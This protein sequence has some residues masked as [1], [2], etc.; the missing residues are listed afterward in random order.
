[1]KLPRDLPKGL[2]TQTID[3]VK[4]F[5]Q[6]S[7]EMSNSKSP[8]FQFENFSDINDVLASRPE[9]FRVYTPKRIEFLEQCDFIPCPLRN[10][11]LAFC[12][13]I[14]KSPEVLLLPT[15]SI[16]TMIRS[17]SN[18]KD[19]HANDDVLSSL[20]STLG[21]RLFVLNKDDGLSLEEFGDHEGKTCSLLLRQGRSF[22]LASFNGDTQGTLDVVVAH[23]KNV[24]ANVK[25][26]PYGG[27]WRSLRNSRHC[28]GLEF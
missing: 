9:S 8:A 19:E 3:V 20:S 11:T 12:A 28:K 27:I 15:K 14:I 6:G 13:L 5:E 23:A 4:G 25:E 1:M 2:V 7:A 18:A 26:N 22:S 24:R 17:S 10:V 16:E 21:V